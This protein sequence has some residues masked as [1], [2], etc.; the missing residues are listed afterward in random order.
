[1]S[2]TISSQCPCACRRTAHC[3]ARRYRP[4][5]A[6]RQS[7]ACAGKPGCGW[8]CPWRFPAGR[9]RVEL[10]VR[11]FTHLLLLTVGAMLVDDGTDGVIERRGVGPVTD[12]ARRTLIEN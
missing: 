1:M 12:P 8:T 9:P 7:P 5:L 2:G 6:A 11:P 10:A 3:G 4:G